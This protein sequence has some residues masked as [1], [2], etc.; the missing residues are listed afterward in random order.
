MIIQPEVIVTPDYPTIKIRN[1]REAVELDTELPKILQSQ[2]WGLGTFFNVIFISHDREK[3]LACA[4]YVVTEE[5]QNLHTSN[6][7]YQPITKTITM[8]KAERITDWWTAD[9][10]KQNPQNE[11]AKIVWNPGK[12]VHQLKVDDKVIYENKDKAE[13]EK[14]AKE[15]A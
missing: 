2:G 1:P 10:P 13:V 15:A 7:E 9:K 5:K 11:I 14:V 3:L 6:S 8:R 12:K 4:T